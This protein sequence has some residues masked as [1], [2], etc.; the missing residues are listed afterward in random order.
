MHWP[1]QCEFIHLDPLNK[2]STNT[3]LGPK[4]TLSLPSSPAQPSPPAPSSKPAKAPNPQ[5]KLLPSPPTHAAPIDQASFLPHS[6]FEQLNLWH[7]CDTVVI[8]WRSDQDPEP[9]TGNI[10]IEAVSAKGA[11]PWLIKTVYSEFNS[12]AWLVNL[13]VFTPSCNATSKN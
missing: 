8:R 5:C 1:R 11:Q 7:T 13:G 6:P 10:V 2:Q 12:G 9:V 4:L 3:S